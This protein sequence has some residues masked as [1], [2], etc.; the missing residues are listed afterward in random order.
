MILVFLVARPS[1]LV[2]TF[3]VEIAQPATAPST[4]KQW[5]LKPKKPI[6]LDVPSPPLDVSVSDIFAKSAL[7]R[8][9]PPKVVTFFATFYC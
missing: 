1:S 5:G 2:A 7:M 6:F 3:F 8:W 4:P 9:N